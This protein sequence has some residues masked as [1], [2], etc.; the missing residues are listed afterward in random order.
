MTVETRTG[1]PAALLG[2]F[3]GILVVV[4]TVL[5]WRDVARGSYVLY[6]DEGNSGPLFGKVERFEISWPV[7]GPLVFAVAGIVAVLC[8]LLAAFGPDSSLR[9]R[10]L[11]RVFSASGWFA[12]CAALFDYRSWNNE[13]F[14]DDAPSTLRIV[15][16]ALAGSLCVIAGACLSPRKA[17]GRD[18]G[19]ETATAVIAAA[20]ALGAALR[21]L[22]GAFRWEE[23]DVAM[24]LLALGGASMA[25]PW[26]GEL[27][28]SVGVRRRIRVVAAGV[29][30]AA[31]SSQ[32]VLYLALGKG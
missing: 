22:V 23:L 2:S 17:D 7:I 24:V 25:L 29:V 14:Y 19:G 12:A 15:A 26:G 9:R 13:F 3:G 28:T 16:V 10:H 4:T 30:L 5:L 27:L 8:G 32:W 21:V 31:G 6:D 1:R 18:L 11:G 20:G